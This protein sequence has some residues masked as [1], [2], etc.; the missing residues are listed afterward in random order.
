MLDF[1]ANLF[2]KRL[3]YRSISTYRSAV[4]AYYDPI[5]NASVGNHSKVSPIM[6]DILMTDLYNEDINLLWD[7][8]RV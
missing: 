3:Q 4:P 2:E 5:N 7:K 8:D 6:T 1:L